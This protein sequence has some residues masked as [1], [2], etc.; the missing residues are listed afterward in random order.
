LFEGWYAKVKN[1]EDILWIIKGYEHPENGYIAIPYLIGKKKISSND[2]IKY[3]PRNFIKYLDCV[4]RDVPVILKESII[5]SYDPHEIFI[6]K[7]MN[8]PQKILELIDV[9]N[10]S[11]VGLIGSYAF[12]LENINSDVDL[13]VFGD[14]RKIY[15]KLKELRNNGLIKNCSNRYNKVSNT[16]SQK[17]YL[18]LSNRRVLDSCY[19]NIPYTI[20]IL[21]QIESKKCYSMYSN[22]SSYKGLIE[23]Y[24]NDESYLVPSFYKVKSIDYGNIELVTWHTRYSELPL[25]KYYFDGTLQRDEIKHKI[26]ISPDLG[27]KIEPIEIWP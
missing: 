17:A 1:F 18:M 24:D 23:I 2:F 12:G 27:G 8:L 21:R 22:I 4:G 26:I 16:M 20:R 11:Y 9:I 7:Y 6:N 5:E 15:E 10:P 14:N 25:G 13:T 19:L 3:T